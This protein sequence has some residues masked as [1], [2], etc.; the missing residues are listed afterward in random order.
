MV[1]CTIGKQVLEVTIGHAI[2]QLDARKDLV[3]P[4]D[5]A[6]MI[7]RARILPRKVAAGMKRKRAPGRVD[8]PDLV[9]TGRQ[10]RAIPLEEGGSG[11]DRTPNVIAVIAAKVV[12][13][14]PK[15]AIRTLD[16]YPIQTCRHAN[17]IS[18][19]RSSRP[20]S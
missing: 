20:G 3:V 1:K 14:D 8:R 15:R 19:A 4:G 11:I 2:R 18:K 10:P 7:A 17:T 13:R 16:L 12:G 6:V 5:K 9:H